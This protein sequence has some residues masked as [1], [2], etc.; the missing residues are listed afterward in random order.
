MEPA[1]VAVAA[2]TPADVGCHAGMLL[3]PQENLQDENPQDDPIHLESELSRSLRRCAGMVLLGRWY[4]AIDAARGTLE[5]RHC[6]QK[7]AV[8]LVER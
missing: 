8:Q 7:M 4:R 1:I 5:G 2:C 3:V 6:W